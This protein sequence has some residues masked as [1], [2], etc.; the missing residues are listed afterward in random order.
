V[1]KCEH[2]NWT[3]W[4]R[5][6]YYGPGL[7]ISERYCKNDGCPGSDYVQRPHQHDYQAGVSDPFAPVGAGLTLQICSGCHDVKH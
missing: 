2:G 3:E 1:S 6:L 4:T 7:D 5:W